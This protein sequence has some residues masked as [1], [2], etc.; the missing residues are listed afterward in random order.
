M[1]YLLDTN[2]I[3]TL[4]KGEPVF[5]ERMRRHRPPDFGVP[6][7]VIHEL[8]YGAF[9][10]RRVVENRERISSLRFNILS[11]DSEDARR[12]GEIRAALSAQGSPIGPY[13]VLI[14]GQAMARGLALITNNRREFDRVH[15][16]RIEDWLNE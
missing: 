7:I 2:A 9:K 16:L 10:S 14:A 3:I 6:A 5:L 12:A 8:Y 13:D 11:F 15:G 1:K 4:F